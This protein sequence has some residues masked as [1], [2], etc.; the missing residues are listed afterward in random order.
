EFGHYAFGFYDEYVI[1][2]GERC[3]AL[4]KYVRPYGFMDCHYSYCEPYASEMSTNATYDSA[5]C[6]NTEQWTKNTLS[7]WRQFSIR[8]SGIYGSVAS[9]IKE[10]NER[11]LPNGLDYLPGPNENLNKLDYDVGRLVVFPITP[12]P[13]SA[14]ILSVKLVGALS[15]DSLPGVTVYHLVTTEA[16]VMQQGKT[17]SDGRLTALGVNLSDVLFAAG[18]LRTEGAFRRGFASAVDNWV[19]GEATVGGSGV[20]GYKTPYQGFGTDSLVMAL[21]TVAGDLP[22]MVKLEYTDSLPVVSVIVKNMFSEPP[23]MTNSAGA[24]DTVMLTVTPRG[25]G[26]VAAMN[27]TL[28]AGGT[29]TV[30]PLDS[31]GARYFFTADYRA[32]TFSGPGQRDLS[33]CQSSSIVSFD[34]SDSTLHRAALLTCPYPVL[35]DGLDPRSLQ[36]GDAHALAFDADEPLSGVNILRIRYP[37]DMLTATDAFNDEMSLRMYHWN[38]SSSQWELVGGTVDTAFSE[39]QAEVTESGIYALF[40]TAVPTD[41]G[42][43]G[44]DTP[45]PRTF[46]LGQNYPNPFNPSTTIEYSLPRRSRVVIEIFNVL[47]R[48]VR[49]LVDEQAEAGRHRVVWDGRNDAGRPVASGVYLY[50]LVADDYTATRKML[51]LK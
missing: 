47:G 15:G 22:A 39:V 25:N 19:Y 8:N 31:T 51:L 44:D 33:G 34:P 43:S 24:G 16:R 9:L 45:L 20:S 12:T 37:K 6:R 26:Y 13:P 2:K 21:K 18:R 23:E 38:E 36:A 5:A 14:N 35:R 28:Q 49:R 27:D 41:V 48:N 40:T 46:A 32:A 10:P 7:C 17:G 29:I 42:D 50:R 3:S 11:H 1:V 4:P 30:R